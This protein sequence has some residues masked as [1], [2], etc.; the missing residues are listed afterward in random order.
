MLGLTQHLFAAEQDFDLVMTSG[1]VSLQQRRGY[2][3]GGGRAGVGGGGG[4][5]RRGDSQEK[6]KK[7]KREGTGMRNSERG[8][9]PE[10]Q[11]F[12]NTEFVC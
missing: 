8:S 10:L 7:K 12:H 1:N 3:L 6:A 11:L 5:E 4:K 2:E 9:A